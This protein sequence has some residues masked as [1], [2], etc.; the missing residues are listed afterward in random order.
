[1]R[2]ATLILPEG[3]GTIAHSGLRNELMD[4]WD[5]YTVVH[6]YGGW[7]DH[8]VD[9]GQEKD[10]EE[11]VLI[12]SIAILEHHRETEKLI[13]LAAKYARIGAQKCVMITSDTGRVHFVKAE[14]ELAPKPT[15]KVIPGNPA[16][17]PEGVP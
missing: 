16:A 2:I 14:A 11:V 15:G 1:M 6:G 9:I 5:G 17:S 7:R 12:Y 3:A 8:G 4:E 13:A 10:I